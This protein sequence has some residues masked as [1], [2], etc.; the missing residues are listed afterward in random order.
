MG[1]RKA[2]GNGPGSPWSWLGLGLSKE[3]AKLVPLIAVLLFIG[4]LM[5]QSD[6]LFGIDADS[7]PL[8]PAP[9]AS[10][11]GPVGAED[12]LTRL[13]RQ[14]AAELEEMLGQIEGAGRVRVMVTLAAGP[15]IQVVKNTTVDQ[16][17][18]TEEAADS[19]TRRIE[20][21]NTREDHV[22]TRSGS[23]EQP[24]IAQTSA[25]EIAG[26]LIVAEGAR[27]VRIRARLLDAAMVALNVPANRIQV[28]PADGR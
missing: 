18:T 13:E 3:Q 12:E 2:P 24:V 25:P 8:D 22:F 11:V 28:V 5:L 20:S 6:E 17:T 27:D 10:L 21:I 4:I 15:A 16:S 26:V 9:G 14:K 7:P 1:E 23:S 19:S